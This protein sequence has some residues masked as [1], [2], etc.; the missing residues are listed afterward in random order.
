M[1]VWLSLWL[2]VGGCANEALNA[3]E[4]AKVPMEANVAQ[5]IAGV[6]YYVS[7]VVPDDESCTY[8]DASLS[9]WGF[10]AEPSQA[11]IDAALE[12]GEPDIQVEI[13]G[14]YE[15]ALE[16]GHYLV[17]G[18]LFSCASLEVR[19]S[20]LWSVH[21]VH[22]FISPGSALRILDPRGLDA[23]ILSFSTRR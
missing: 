13:R 15:Q 22:G 16:P 12:S 4:R 23:S 18:G 20:E 5:G 3:C 2:L 10:E 1:R 21:V 7:D 19:A 14:D 11:Q 8:R 6:S 9:V 17:C